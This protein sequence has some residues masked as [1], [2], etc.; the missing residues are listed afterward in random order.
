MAPMTQTHTYI[1]VYCILE[2][3]A[4]RQID[5][6]FL[7][8]S[9]NLYKTRKTQNNKPI[10]H[11][12]WNIKKTHSFFTGNEVQ[13]QINESN[14]AQIRKHKYTWAYLEQDKKQ[15]INLA[16]CTNLQYTIYTYICVYQ[17][18]KEINSDGQTFHQYQQNRQINSDG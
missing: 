14:L 8:R 15:M 9:S 18:N 4:M 7:A 16:H 10:L 17:Q 12:I 6:L 2:V 13:I 1:C 5:H 11:K 3:R